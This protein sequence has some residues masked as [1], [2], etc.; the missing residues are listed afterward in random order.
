MNDSRAPTALVS[1]AHRDE[2][3]S[4][5]QAEEW[6]ARVVKFATLL[7]FNGVDADLDLWNEIDPSTDWTRWGQLKVQECELVLVAVSVAWRQRWE[8]TNSPLK[9]AGAV[10]EADTLKGLF[11]KDQDDF[12]RRIVLVQLP[13]V[14]LEAIPTDLHRLRRFTVKSL[15]SLGMESLLRSIHKQPL[16]EKPALGPA[17]VYAPASCEPGGPDP[18][19][20]AAKRGELDAAK[21][22]VLSAPQDRR[23]RVEADFQRPLL[24]A[25][26]DIHEVVRELVSHL[27]DATVAQL[28]DVNDESVLERWSLPDGPQPRNGSEARLRTAHLICDLVRQAVGVDSAISWFTE[29]NSRLGGSSPAASLR[30]GRMA[31]VRAAADFFLQGTDG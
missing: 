6:I 20:L 23:R 9:G 8:G 29:S 25:R 31:E 12:Q 30:D 18:Q 15:D 16:H 3:W 2:R 1:W 11:S 17:P 24:T 26:I 4:D 7:R 27:G 13:G 5:R 14:G 19:A 22:G 10:A 28:A 21:S